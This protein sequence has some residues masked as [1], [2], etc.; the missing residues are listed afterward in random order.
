M[1]KKKAMDQFRINRIEITNFKAIDKIEMDFFLPKMKADPD[2]YVMGSRN[3][4]GKTSILEACTLLSLAAHSVEKRWN[5]SRIPEISMNL[6]ELFIRSGAET[7]SVSGEFSL[8]ESSI[9]VSVNLSKDG[10]I[11]IDGDS[12]KIRKIL[13]GNS[14]TEELVER[15]FMLQAGYN[16]EPV[17]MQPCLYFHSYR[18][19][20]EGNPELGMMVESDRIHRRMMIR[21]PYGRVG[22][23]PNGN[24]FVSTFKLQILRAMMGKA[25]LFE[26]LDS[27]NADETLDRLNGLIDRYAGGKIAKLRPSPD[28][29]VD[30]RISPVGGGESFAFDGLS[31]GQ[32]EIISTLFLIWYY[33]R[34]KPCLILIDEPELHLNAEWHRDFVQQVF[35]LAPNNQYIIATHSEDIFK[36]VNEDRRLF[37]GL[38]NNEPS[39]RN[40]VEN[41]R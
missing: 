1:V 11:K 2:I 33:T 25:N 35:K 4:L 34:Q 40:V 17:I 22:I 39:R 21:T 18:K 14:S 3:G 12:E 32:K 24:M 27:K 30:F 7:A 36:S 19:V 10:I 20:Q 26:R 37:F 29:T 15:F 31:S 6:S 38:S 28:N 5:V 9:T 8:N 41:V 13:P 23:A 16:M